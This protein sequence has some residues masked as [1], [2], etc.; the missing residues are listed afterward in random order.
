MFLF[1]FWKYCFCQCFDKVAKASKFFGK[2]ANS[3]FTEYSWKLGITRAQHFVN[4]AVTVPGTWGV[5]RDHVCA[6]SWEHHWQMFPKGTCSILRLLCFLV[7]MCLENFY[8]D[9]A[10]PPFRFLRLPRDKVEG[11]RKEIR[12]DHLFSCFYHCIDEVGRT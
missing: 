3:C 6:Q 8:L 2:F 1:C 11:M 9:C 12:W 7:L 5:S 10:Q 4:A